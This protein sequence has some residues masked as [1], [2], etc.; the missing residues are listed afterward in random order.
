MN[1]FM[2]ICAH[3]CM[4]AAQIIFVVNFFYSMFFGPSRG[5]NPWHA[6]GLEW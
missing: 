1:Q 6:N 3:S 5:R 4:V 2:T